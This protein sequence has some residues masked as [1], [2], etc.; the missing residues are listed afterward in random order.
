MADSNM[1][2]GFGWDD[3][4]TMT[5]SEFVLF[6]P[7]EY[8]YVVKKFE[9]GWFDGSP[10]M[11]ACNMAKLT[12]T[13]TDPDTGQTGDVFVN[14]MLNSKVMFRITQFFKS[15]GLIAPDAPNGERV[16]ASLFQQSVGR[17][18]R[19]KLKHREYNGREYNDVDEF[20]KPN[21]AATPTPAPA[22]TQQQW[23][24]TF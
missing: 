15:C 21:A 20:V 18:G 10:K 19:V 14:L 11:A 2:Q 5:E 16:K 7:G 3:E 23:G 12:I 6:E 13:V 1:G 9:R 8:D 22:P 17:T 4:L 24:G